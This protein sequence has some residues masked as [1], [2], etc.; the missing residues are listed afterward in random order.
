MALGPG[1]YEG[2]YGAAKYVDK[3]SAEQIRLKCR[4]LGRRSSQLASAVRHLP[5]SAYRCRLSSPRGSTNGLIE[6]RSVE[7]E[8]MR[9]PNSAS[10]NERRLSSTSDNSAP[11]STQ[12]GT[13]RSLPRMVETGHMRTY[14]VQQTTCTG[15]QLF[16]IALSYGRAPTFAERDLWNSRQRGG[17]CGTP[18]APYSKP[19]AFR[20][21]WAGGEE[22][23]VTSALAASV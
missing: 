11:V 19:F 6:H 17:P 1:H 13:K 15:A 8:I 12:I 22:R 23:N 2:Y 10:G 21:V 5:R 20:T 9:G 16:T 4:S 18:H 3:I 14:A 7:R